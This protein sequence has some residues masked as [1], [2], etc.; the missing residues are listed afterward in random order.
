MFIDFLENCKCILKDEIKDYEM[1]KLSFKND[2]QTP[3]IAFM[4][5][6]VDD[7]WPIHILETTEAHRFRDDNGKSIY[8]VPVG[9]HD[10]YAK[11]TLENKIRDFYENDYLDELEFDAE[12]EECILLSCD[13][14]RKDILSEELN[15]CNVIYL[16]IEMKTRSVEI[17][18]IVDYQEDVW[19]RIV[20]RYSLNVSYIIESTKGMGDWY[21]CVPLYNLVMNTSLS[22]GIPKYY[23]KGRYASTEITDDYEELYEVPESYSQ[24]LKSY[25]YK[26]RSGF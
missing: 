14:I 23:M 16:R 2:E 3:F 8:I 17:F 20:E 6:I 13:D 11:F 4:P 15:D 25:I 10:F 26:I 12:L 18:V 22:S 21:Y 1:I 24:G 19:K 9:A 7:L 5:L